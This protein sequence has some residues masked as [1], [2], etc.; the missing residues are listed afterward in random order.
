MKQMQ[1]TLAAR[2]ATKRIRMAMPEEE[3]R[4]LGLRLFA[5]LSGKRSQQAARMRGVQPWIA[6]NKARRRNAAIRREQLHVRA[7]LLDIG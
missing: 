5:I 2:M 3:R 6:A 4:A 1:K 7:K